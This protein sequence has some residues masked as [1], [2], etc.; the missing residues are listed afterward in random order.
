MRYHPIRPILFSFAA[1]FAAGIAF[2]GTLRAQELAELCPEADA[3]GGAL[4]GMVQD[5][6]I[7]MILP[8]AEVTASWV[9]EGT[10]RRAT[11]EV[12][13]DG[14]FT[15]CGLPRDMGSWPFASVSPTSGV[16]W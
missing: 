16:P 5:S 9:V 14:T 12:A 7:G 6:D 4:V 13:V 3:A 10:R 8:G 1:A 11:A 2:N 15:L